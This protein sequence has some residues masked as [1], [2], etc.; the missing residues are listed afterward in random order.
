MKTETDILEFEKELTRLIGRFGLGK[1]ANT[2]CDILADV[3]LD[4]YATFTDATYTRDERRNQKSGCRCQKDE[5][6]PEKLHPARD[7]GNRPEA[8]HLGYI[9]VKPVGPGGKHEAFVSFRN[10]HPLIT[11]TANLAMIFSFREMAEDVAEKL[12]NGWEV[13]DLDDLEA[14]RDTVERFLKCL[15]AE[16]LKDGNEQLRGCPADE[17]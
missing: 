3:M 5:A 17:E 12:G 14:S 1:M 15:R 7:R 10:Y 6:R 16:D 2:P 11:D 9:G 4:A 8:N 13:L